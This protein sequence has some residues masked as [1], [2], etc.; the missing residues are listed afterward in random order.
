MGRQ[1]SDARAQRARVQQHSARFDS[2]DFLKP[3]VVIAK[4]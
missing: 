4:I 3:L 2:V 1:G